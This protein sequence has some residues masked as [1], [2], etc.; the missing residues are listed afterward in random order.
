[1]SGWGD[2]AITAVRYNYDDTRIKQVKRKEVMPDKLTNT[3]KVDRS[4]VVAGIERGDDYTTSIKN[5]DSGKW[6]LGDDVH[7]LEING[8]KFIR[9]DKN[10]TKEDNLGGLPTF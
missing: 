2:Y 10:S 1:M 9:T 8:E 4:S 7:V 6:D 5:E 3:Q